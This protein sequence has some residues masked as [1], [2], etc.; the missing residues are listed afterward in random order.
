MHRCIDII[1][2]V[3][4]TKKKMLCA[5]DI[6]VSPNNCSLSSKICI[7]IKYVSKAELKNKVLFVAKVRWI[8]LSLL[9]FNY[10]KQ[11]NRNIQYIPDVVQKS[12]NQGMF[13]KVV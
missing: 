13:H 5:T 9:S 10:I 6:E 3:W 7:N 1:D 11:I 8:S 4:S 12:S 2:N